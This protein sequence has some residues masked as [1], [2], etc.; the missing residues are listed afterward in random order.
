[1]TTRRSALPLFG[2]ALFLLLSRGAAQEDLGSF[3]DTVDVRV[4]NV[5]VVVTDG[6]GHP[7]VG[8]TPEDFRVRED[9]EPVEL[10][11]FLAVRDGTVRLAG[12]PATAPD[13]EAP[14]AIPSPETQRLNLVVF[15][16]QR[17]IRPET[18]NRVIERLD[19]YL[20]D[21]VRPDDRV[22]L[23]A[24][25][26]RLEVLQRFT[27]SP[28]VLRH[29][30]D[31]LRRRVGFQAATDSEYR[32][33]LRR[34]QQ[35]ALELPP[36]DLGESPFGFEGAVLEAQRIARDIR[37][38]AERRH[39]EARRSLDALARFTDSLAGLEGRKAVLYV[40]EGV[41]LAPARSLVEAWVGKFGDWA[42]GTGQQNLS[43]ELTALM[44]L[45]YDLDSDLRRLVRR[46]ATNRVVLYP[47][48]AAGGF[49]GS[50]LSAETMGSG[51]TSGSG[52]FSLDV[53]NVEAVTRESGLLRIAQGTGGLAFLRN[54]DVDRAVDSIR[55]DFQTFYSL[56]Y[57][58]THPPDG[59]FHE[60]TVEL[61]NP[62]LE[63]RHLGGYQ[64]TEPLARLEDLTLSAALYGLTPNSLGLA[65]TPMNQ[66][67]AGRKRYRVTVLVTIPFTNLVLLPRRSDFTGQVTLYVLVRGPQNDLS[68]IQQV[69][70]PLVIPGNRLAEAL[71]RTA[72]YPMVLEMR[73]G[74]HVVAVGARDHLGQVDAT[75]TLE[76]DVPW[77]E[78]GG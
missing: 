10:T 7:V 52:P 39:N 25:E 74:H 69:E 49:T 63:V 56:G 58:P 18:R 76:I 29:S 64:Q 6:E 43:R 9:G 23:V 62:D 15:V 28:E 12:I 16:D 46:A 11:N 22:M 3:V 66:E 5:E 47:L 72:A 38:V 44:G 1:M 55:E 68:D 30:L 32:D 13:P 17:N 21:R 59:T 33:L 34:M 70:I 31:E 36:R 73:A 53:G 48:T 45:E 54:P 35:T 71:Q 75:A 42:V 37:L 27:S 20:E 60:V 2:C 78:D 57:R 65:L 67:R 19:R 50:Q 51:T 4:V 77:S 41:P 26:D 40:S 61:L 24:F 8:L 14:L